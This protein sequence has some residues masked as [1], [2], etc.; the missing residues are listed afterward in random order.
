MEIFIAKAKE[1]N[2]EIEI[3]LVSTMLP[4]P[5]SGWYENQEKYVYK[6]LEIE[7]EYPRVAVADMTT[8]NLDIFK[9][10]RFRDITGNNIN[11]PNDFLIRVYAQVII[12]TIIGDKL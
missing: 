6:L 10:K 1:N 4:N 3:I 9:R 8:M 7:Q 12:E 2:P 5:E 11:H